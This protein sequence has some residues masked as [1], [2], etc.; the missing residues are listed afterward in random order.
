MLVESAGE[1][2]P[3]P[4]LVHEPALAADQEPAAHVEQE[5]APDAA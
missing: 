2:V 1:D 4:Q 3:A 5:L